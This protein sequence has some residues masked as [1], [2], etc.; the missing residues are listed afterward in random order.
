[1][2]KGRPDMLNVTGKYIY[3]I[4]N[5]GSPSIEMMNILQAERVSAVSFQDISALISDSEVTDLRNMNKESLAK[6]LLGHQIIVEKIMKYYPVM[7]VSIGTIVCGEDEVSEAL[8]KGYG[9]IKDV[10]RK[11]ENIVEV[12]VV[13]VWSD[14]NSALQE[15][16]REPEIVAL[17][18]TLL[19]KPEGI[20]IEDQMQVGFMVKKALNTK[21]GKYAGQIQKTLENIVQGFKINEVMDE[22][23]IINIACS[24]DK[25]QQEKFDSVVEKLDMEFNDK[26]NFRCV[27]P[28]PPYNFCTLGI[29]KMP[30]EE[31]CSAKNLLGLQDYSNRDEIKKAYRK[32]ALLT[33]PDRNPDDSGNK[34]GNTA[35]A[36]KVLMEYCQEERC[37]FR[38]EDFE[39]SALLV[40]VME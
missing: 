33:H 10:F 28:L 29:K 8:E 31:I 5:T 6:I 15:A 20:T 3:G 1:M 11:I 40:Q 22:S 14:F 36:Y 26:V 21:R 18:E 30:F 17:K 38:K 34:F 39:K 16:S 24:V 13:A 12:D 37:S 7:P 4:I 32:S 19:S 27:G 23:M 9:V 25:D 35:N 2:K